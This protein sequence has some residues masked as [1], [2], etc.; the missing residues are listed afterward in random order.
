VTDE[1][2]WALLVAAVV[3]T[4]VAYALSTVVKA[5]SAGDGECPGRDDCPQCAALFRHPSQAA[6][7]RTLAQG[8]K[9]QNR[10]GW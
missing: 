5:R 9:P 1:T 4:P 10:K 7:R 6:T 8:I 3:L 2:L